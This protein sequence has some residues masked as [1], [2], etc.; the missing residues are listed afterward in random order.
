MKVKVGSAKEEFAHWIKNYL[1]LV[2]HKE[3]LYKPVHG[4]VVEVTTAREEH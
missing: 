3:H 1:T 2:T 4:A